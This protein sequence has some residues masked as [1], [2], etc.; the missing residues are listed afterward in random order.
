MVKINI[1][2]MLIFLMV[3]A[4]FFSIVHAAGIEFSDI[5]VKVGSKTSNGLKDGET[6]DDEAKPGDSLEFRVQV[7]NN[8]TELEIQDITVDVTIEE[9]DDGSD[10][11]D[12]SSDFNLNP[13]RDKRVT[14]KF[15]VPENANEDTFNVIIHAEGEDENGTTQEIE[16]SLD[17]EVDRET[18]QIK[19]LSKSLSPSELLCGKRNSQLSVHMINLG[20]EDED[21]VFLRVFN[22]DLNLDVTED[23][24]EMNSDSDDDTNEFS[25]IFNII[26]PKDIEPGSYPIT[27]R[28]TYDNDRRKAEDVATLTVNACS[29]IVP[30]PP[31]I[32]PPTPNPQPVVQN[33]PAQTIKDTDTGVSEI[34]LDGYVTQESLF[35]DSTLLWVA[36]FFGIFAIIVIIFVV[37]FLL[38]K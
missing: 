34:P 24:G 28:A 19:I 14:L 37:L 21:D 33:P 29:A 12:E 13:G 7:R 1:K 9:I 26:V 20:S 6:I 18:H 10:L 16:I 23:I 31:V 4:L 27:L 5:D 32:T 8:L 2:S 15:N 3:F 36:I 22:P 25:R 17:L 35:G 11:D 30:Q 38:K